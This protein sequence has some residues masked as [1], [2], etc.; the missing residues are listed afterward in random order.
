MN[1]RGVAPFAILLQFEFL[2]LLL[3]VDCRR[4]VAAFALR[5]GESDDVCHY[6]ISSSQVKI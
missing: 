2:C 5:A 4:V 1:C 6:E 3:F